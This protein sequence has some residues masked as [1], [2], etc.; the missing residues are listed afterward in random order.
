MSKKTI[1]GEGCVLFH[2]AGIRQAGHL[3]STEAFFDTITVKPKDGVDALRKRAE[4][5]EINVRL[6]DEIH[7]RHLLALFF[8]VF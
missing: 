6:R 4:A 3:V 8:F 5:V 2:N 7:V 1:A